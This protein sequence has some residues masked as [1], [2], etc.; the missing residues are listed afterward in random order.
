MRAARIR[1]PMPAIDHE[2]GGPFSALLRSVVWA[3]RVWDERVDQARAWLIAE[4]RRR[5]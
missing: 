1:H 4:G 5:R 2:A 3:L